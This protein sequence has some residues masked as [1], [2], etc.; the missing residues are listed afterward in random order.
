ML[1]DTSAW[2]PSRAY[3]AEGAPPSLRDLSLCGYQPGPQSGVLSTGNRSGLCR[4]TPLPRDGPGEAGD[5]SLLEAHSLLC[6]EGRLL[7]HRDSER[8]RG[9]TEVGLLSST[10]PSINTTRPE[11]SLLSPACPSPSPVPVRPPVTHGVLQGPVLAQA[12]AARPRPWGS[13]R[14]LSRP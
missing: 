9:G 7:L 10:S 8:Q 6:T 14:E 12:W 2:S 4:H 1:G 13:Q 3:V 11:P 5:W